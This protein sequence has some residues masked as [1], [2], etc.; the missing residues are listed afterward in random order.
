MDK[1]TEIIQKLDF[2]IS[3][4]SK[5]KPLNHRG[6]LCDEEGCDHHA[7]SYCI[8]CVAYTCDHHHASKHLHVQG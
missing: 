4:L 2:I 7:N 1:E 8:L 6:C 5:P 3:L